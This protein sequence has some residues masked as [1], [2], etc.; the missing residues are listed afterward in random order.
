MQNTG[1]I[2]IGIVGCGTISSYYVKN[3][4][5]FPHI[6]VAACADLDPAK[7]TALATE[8]GIP[9]TLTTEQLLSDPE[10]D[11]V[12]NLTIP[13]AHASVARAALEHGKSVYNEKPLTTTRDEAVELL[14]LAEERGLR[15]GCAPDTFLGAGPQSAIRFIQEGGLGDPVGA[16]AF[17]MSRGM[18]HWHPNPAF[19][20]KPG[21]GPLFDMGP[22]YLTYLCAIFGPV[23]RVSAMARASFPERVV[24]SQPNPGTVIKVE[25]PTHIVANLEF[26]NGAL[27]TIGMSFDVAA[28]HMPYL[29]L[30]GSEATLSLNNPNFFSGDVL[31]C[32]RG[33]SDW[34]QLPL[35]GPYRDNARGVGVAEMAWAIQTGQPHR[36][37]GQLALHVLDI[38]QSTLEAAESGRRL[39][40]T[41]SM[42]PPAPLPEDLKD[43]SFA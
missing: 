26:V 33:E 1:K 43:W 23:R 21:A 2:R 4:V 10:I 42:T 38:M 40:L 37:N 31:L 14:R 19:Y 20:Y 36:A 12:L 34:Q 6:T 18:E 28:H 16:T 24:T 5:L 11:L 7:A 13:A 27:A 17:M 22:Y 35:S 9:R 39:D 15:V 8:F 3:L 41:T 25:T 29:E 30:F 32:R